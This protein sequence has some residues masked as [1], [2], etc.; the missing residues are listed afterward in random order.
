MRYLAEDMLRIDELSETQA[1]SLGDMSC[2]GHPLVDLIHEALD[3]DEFSIGADGMIA[4]LPSHEP[5]FH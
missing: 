4:L 2:L 5:V 1:L 3:L